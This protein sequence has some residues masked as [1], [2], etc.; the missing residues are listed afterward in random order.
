MTTSTRRRHTTQSTALT[1]SFDDAL[2]L[3]HDFHRDDVRKGTTIPYVSHL[4]QVAGLVVEAGG[5]QE[6][7][8]AALLHDAIEDAGSDEEAAAR[9]RRI[10]EEFGDRVAR[11]VRGC[12]DGVPD[13][14][15]R[16]KWKARKERYLR[17]LRH[18]AKDEVLLISAADKLH[19]ARAILRDYRVHGEDLWDRF[20]GG[21]GGTL[22]YYRGLVRTYQARGLE[23]MVGELDEVVSLLELQAVRGS[24]LHV[25][26]WLETPGFLDEINAL[27]QPFG[28]TVS[29][30]DFWQPRGW[31]QPDE[32]K[33]D[34]ALADHPEAE[35]DPLAL[36][37]WWL[38]HP[39]GANVPNWD[40][41]ATCRIDGKPGL[42]L[43]EAEA[44][45]QELSSLG[46][47][48]PGK[49]DSENSHENDRRIRKAI[50]EAR[51]GLE[52]QIAGIGIS[53]EHAY[54]FSN[55]IAI[56]WWLAKEGTPVIL[57]YL[58]FLG[59]KEMPK[60]FGTE[61]AWRDCVRDHAAPVFPEGGFDRWI[62]A[63]RASFAVVRGALPVPGDQR[64]WPASLPK[65]R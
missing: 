14:K 23:P 20:R 25:L 36:E 51:I 56:A 18:E 4:I 2:R 45:A 64:P 31:R 61:D 30:N 39:R 15:S 35:F 49:R 44:H 24:R 34:R 27:V 59:D 10:R 7:A 48:R 13:E 55:R 3:A 26:N 29:R 19:N 8:I 5:D 17:H 37:G 65:V 54:Q 43:V 60:S 50:A 33:I 47:K 28:A 16:M 32:A 11:L 46:K 42:V 1:P 9:E 58:A 63:G 22:W 21:K 57:L 38:K 53:A 6:Q 40:L 41:L 12:T 62:D 52:P